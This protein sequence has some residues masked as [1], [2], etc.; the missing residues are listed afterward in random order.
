MS[1]VDFIVIVCNQIDFTKRCIES[2]FRN[3]KE[4]FHLI[5]I[6]N[7]S[8]DSTRA[9]LENLQKRQSATQR[10]SVFFSQT[11]LG[12][13]LGLNKG[14]EYSEAPFVFFCNNDIEFYPGAVTELIRIAKTKPEF[15]LVNPNS[16][17]FGLKGYDE[18][19]LNRQKG[20]WIERCHTS[21]FCVLVK[22]EVIQKIGGID[23]NFS[24]AYYEDMDF[25]ER[26]KRAGFLCVV[27]KGAY[28]HHFGTRTFLP[29]EKQ[30]LWDQN[31]EK[32]IQKWGGTK[33][34]LCLAG[35]S[36]VQDKSEREKLIAY[37]LSLARKEIAVIYIMVPIGFGKYF[38]DFHDSFRVIEMPDFLIFISGV[39]RLWRSRSK[40]P[41]SRLVISGVGSKKMW[42]TISQNQTQVFDL[43]K[44]AT[45]S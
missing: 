39:V 41:I 14:I 37:L 28:I 32:F 24:P 4:S 5:I 13:A 33:W 2:I 11:N 21:G 38:S 9:Y 1:E 16:N 45:T 27:A 34:F 18:S 12:Y 20:R 6:D 19:Y 29:K 30:S 31:R 8:T 36:V 44:E 3:V 22:R 25:A 42:K 35:R 43:S 17:E 26:A 15:G 40:K 23:P 10:L 7:G